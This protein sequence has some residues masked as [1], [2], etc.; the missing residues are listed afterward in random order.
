MDMDSAPDL[1]YA[2][3]PTAMDRNETEYQKLLAEYEKA[4][5]AYSRAIHT[6]AGGGAAKFKKKRWLRL[7]P[8]TLN[9]M[10]S[11]HA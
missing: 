5:D 4:V 3:K 9:V 11:A 2:E 7:L 8:L 10:I 1:A 6:L